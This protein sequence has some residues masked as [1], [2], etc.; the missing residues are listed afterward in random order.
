[1]SNIKL[2]KSSFIY[3]VASIFVNGGNILLLP[4]YTQYLTPKD[5]GIISSVLI[6][7]TL[8]T[9]FFSLGLNAAINRYFF[10]IKNILEFRSFLFTTVIFQFG[11]SLII[12]AFVFLNNG[13][14]LNHL[15]KNITYD[16]YL[17]LGLII[18]LLGVFPTIPLGLLS[19]QGQA[20]KYRII[21]ISV[22]VLTTLFMLYFVVYKKQGAVGALKSQLFATSIVAIV[23]IVFILIESI[24]KFQIKYL[25]K[26]ISFGI[27]LM[28]YAIFGSANDLS[29]KYFVE[30]FSTLHD[31]GI[32][33]L[34]L[35][36]S[37]IPLILLSA[38]N[39]A[40]LPIFYSTD[41]NSKKNELFSKYLMIV[42]CSLSLL[43]ALFSHEIIII[44]A[45]RN[46]VKAEIYL[47]FLV[48]GLTFLNT[49]WILFSNALN[50]TKKTIYLPLITFVSFCFSIVSNLYMVPK[51]GVYGA[52]ISLV[53]ANIILNIF[54]FI[55]F[56][57][58]TNFKYAFKQI[59]LTF[60]SSL[61]IYSIS[62]FFKYDYPILDIL[63]NIFLFI[64]FI[65]LL[66]ILKIISFRELLFTIKNKQN[67]T[68]RD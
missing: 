48:L 26:A 51:Y 22:F 49:Y 35:Q 54:A 39:L 19:A 32:L 12:T 59:N 15:F 10:D 50:F 4:L 11:F 67:I 7:S 20:F 65:A 30:R 16:P 27:P 47:P 56:R 9:S 8:T 53:L 28:V 66:N 17:K 46:F 29:S 33:N 5:Y 3:F 68:W 52:C 58:I 14:F 55:I 43:I 24:P 61:I 34:A 2:V 41:E 57:K 40:W 42:M 60:I 23:C 18:G 13:L 63:M 62:V 31:L 64:L 45:T 25:E 1:M 37:A 44:L 38:I 36:I 6:L 21:T